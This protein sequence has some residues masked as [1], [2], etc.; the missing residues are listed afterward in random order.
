MSNSSQ[1]I[2]KARLFKIRQESK[3]GLSFSNLETEG[4]SKF[5]QKL[6]EDNEQEALSEVKSCKSKVIKGVQSVST[7]NSFAESCH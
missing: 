2:V 6:E 1:P 7:M 4:I 5:K 3:L